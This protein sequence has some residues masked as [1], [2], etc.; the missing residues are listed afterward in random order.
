MHTSAPDCEETPPFTTIGDGQQPASPSSPD[1]APA[2]TGTTDPL[3]AKAAKRLA[4]VINDFKRDLHQRDGTWAHAQGSLQ[5]ARKAQNSEPFTLTITPHE[6]GDEHPVTVQAALKKPELI[7]IS[8]DTT[9][10]AQPILTST[11]RA[12]DAELEKDIVS[13]KK[14]KREDG[15]QQTNKRSRANDDE[16]VENIMPLITKEDINHLLVKLREDIQ[17]D[18]TETVNHVQRLLRRFKEEWHEKSKWDLEQLQSRQSGAPFGN[19]TSAAG[20]G[21]HDSFPSPDVDRDDINASVVDVVRRETG[22]LS[23]Q[24]KWVEDCRRVASKTH[25]KRE[26]TWRTTSAGFHDKQRQD[27]ENFQNRMVHESTMHSQTLNQILNEVKAIGLYAQNMK[28][29]TPSY[30]DHMPTTSPQVPTFP[31]QTAQ[32]AFPKQAAR[33]THT[34]STGTKQADQ[35]QRLTRKTG[36]GPGT[37]NG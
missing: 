16:D 26:D 29:E 31:T 8:D 25:V 27:R 5:L 15:D 37:Q 32:P 22:L 2:G 4:D 19:A 24:I 36:R 7:T 13:R 11:R 1:S 3:V 6:D 20:A 9:P 12:S 10:T 33:T 23:R 30:L 18:T 34:S 14:R 17:E 28:W 35:N 21:S